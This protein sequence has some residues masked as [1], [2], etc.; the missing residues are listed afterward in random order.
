[1]ALCTQEDSSPACRAPLEI[2]LGF[3][4]IPLAATAA[5]IGSAQPACPRVLGEASSGHFTRL[6]IATALSRTASSCRSRD[7][8]LLLLM[9]SSAVS[10]APEGSAGI[11]ALA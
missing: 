8:P 7:A 2:L 1:M 4:L 9:E 6:G 3:L 11:A 10:G 5:L